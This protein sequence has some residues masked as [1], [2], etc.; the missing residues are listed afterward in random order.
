[1]PHF[2]LKTTLII[3]AITCFGVFILCVFATATIASLIGLPGNVVTMAGWIC[4]PCAL[5]ML[6][7]GLQKTP[8]KSLARLIA[9]G[10]LGWVAAS[11]AVVVL[12][13]SQMTVLGIA[14]VIAQAVFVLYLALLESK[15]AA[16]LPKPATA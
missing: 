4:L 11:L 14:F 5:L 9:V 13:I 12:F 6:F 1:M 16:A 7:A 2:N 8:S 3:D 10:N 15:G